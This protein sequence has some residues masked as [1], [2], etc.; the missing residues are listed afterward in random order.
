[1]LSSIQKGLKKA[2][3]DVITSQILLETL[4]NVKTGST[5]AHLKKPFPDC[6][7]GP[8][9]N[10]TSRLSRKK[11]ELSNKTLIKNLGRAEH[12][13]SRTHQKGWTVLNEQSVFV[14]P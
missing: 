13:F 5:G 8:C 3:L 9:S 1:M 12:K 6:H 10:H 7:S 11:I 14:E 2:F 4:T